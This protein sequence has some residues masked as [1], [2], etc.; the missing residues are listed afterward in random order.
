[1]IHFPLAGREWKWE[2]LFKFPRAAA[3][4]PEDG[5]QV[6]RTCPN[7]TSGVPH[8][9]LP[10]GV[11]LVSYW[12]GLQSSC[13]PVL[14]VWYPLPLRVKA[15]LCLWQLIRGLLRTGS[16]SHPCEGSLGWGDLHQG[17]LLS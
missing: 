14:A 5:G 12:D 13:S 15:G 2:T 16:S 3:S 11:H 6:K 8:L 10:L 17:T 9:R 7:C 1:M 4:P